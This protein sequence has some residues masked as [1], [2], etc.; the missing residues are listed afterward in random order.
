MLLVRFVL[1]AGLDSTRPVL[2]SAGRASFANASRWIED[3]REARGTDVLVVLCGN[4]TDLVDKRY[5][6]SCE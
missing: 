6:T 4:K 1:C 3:V 5:G 2:R